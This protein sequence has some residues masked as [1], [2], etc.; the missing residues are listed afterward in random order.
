MK[1]EAAMVASEA[2]HARLGLLSD[3]SIRSCV[4]ILPQLSGTPGFGIK[5]GPAPGS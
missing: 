3:Q 5:T 4:D 2:L 1:A